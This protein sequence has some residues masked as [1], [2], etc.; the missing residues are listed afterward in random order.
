[1]KDRPPR[2]PVPM[3][4]IDNN[5]IGPLRAVEAKPVGQAL[6][7]HNIVDARILEQLGCLG[8][9]AWADA[10]DHCGLRLHY[11]PAYQTGQLELTTVQTHTYENSHD[12]QPY[13][14][15]RSVDRFHHHL[16]RSARTCGPVRR[17]LEHGRRDYQRPLR[18]NPDWPW[19]KPR[20][21]LFHWRIFRFLSDS[22]ERPRFRIGAGP[23]ECSGWPAHSP[24]DRTVQS[25]SGQRD[26]GRYRAFR[27]L[28]GRLERHSLVTHA[29]TH[30]TR[31]SG[32]GLLAPVRVRAA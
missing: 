7:L 13:A 15:L 19:N 5:H 6:R 4:K 23:D 21:N 8:G 22:V 28:F 32:N 16:C 3:V 10:T 31:L 25:V 2:A 29:L 1:M 17:K 20:P 9:A 12:C 14:R 11:A 30:I 18:T 26:V 24:W 27:F